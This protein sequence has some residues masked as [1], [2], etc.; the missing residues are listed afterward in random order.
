MKTLVI[1]ITL[2]VI[3]Y[4][5]IAQFKQS[6]AGVEKIDAIAFAEKIKEEGMLI[7]DVRTPSEFQAGHIKGAVNI[8]INSPDFNEKIQELEK[9]KTLLVYCHSGARSAKASKVLNE[10]G[11]APIFDMAGGIISWKN[12]KLPVE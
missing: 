7:L 12:H 4:F 2:M 5:A 1:I 8:D 10:Q 6:P 11:F 3:A 9:S